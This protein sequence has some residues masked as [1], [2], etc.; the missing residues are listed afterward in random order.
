M[1]QTNAQRRAMFA[2]I[3]ALAQ[4]D[5]MKYK[6]IPLG[7]RA[8]Y[9]FDRFRTDPT[10]RALG[11]LGIVGGLGTAGVLLSPIL[12]AIAGSEIGAVTLGHIAPYLGASGGAYMGISLVQKG[13][14]I[15]RKFAKKIQSIN[16][17]RLT[18][19]NALIKKGVPKNQAIAI[20]REEAIQRYLKAR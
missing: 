9:Q 11:S 14:K 2:R 10:T 20:S 19:F 16:K 17:Q 13:D 3:A 8:S 1:K 5:V 18:R 6:K 15:S 7:K 12:P 4:R